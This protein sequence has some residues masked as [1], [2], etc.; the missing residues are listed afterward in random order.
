MVPSD[1][2]CSPSRGDSPNTRARGADDR[3]ASMI[4]FGILLPVFVL[5]AFGIVEFGPSVGC[6]TR[7]SW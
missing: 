6:S 5:F 4:E 1:P 2:A 3:G 7:R